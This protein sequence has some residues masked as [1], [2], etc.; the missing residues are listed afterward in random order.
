MN[1]LISILSLLPRSSGES[2]CGQGK[3]EWA[4]ATAAVTIIAIA[5]IPSL[6][7][8]VITAIHSAFGLVNIAIFGQ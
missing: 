4:I 2:E 7:E 1:T 3:V 6:R 5:A 8:A